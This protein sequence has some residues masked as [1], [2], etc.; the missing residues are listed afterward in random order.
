MNVFVVAEGKA[1]PIE[2][3]LEGGATVEHLA[4]EAAE[5]LEF[6]QDDVLIFIENQDEPL[7]A[8]VVIEE[9]VPADRCFH[10]HRC[11][12]VAVSVTYNQKTIAGDFSPATTIGRLR[13]WAIRHDDFKFHENDAACL[14]LQLPDGTFP[15]ERAHAGQFAK[16]PDCGVVFQLAEHKKPQG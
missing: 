5:R 16:H 6:V 13:E 8:V 15:D 3:D 1:D 11:R 12:H 4:A 10:A 14:R 2:I 9:I 7:S